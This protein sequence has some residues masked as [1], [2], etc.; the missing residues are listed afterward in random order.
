MPFR[1]VR[2]REGRNHRVYPR[3]AR[4]HRAGVAHCGPHSDAKSRH[5]R[6]RARD[7]RPVLEQPTDQLVARPQRH[8]STFSSGARANS[9]AT[10]GRCGSAPWRT[11]YRHCG[12]RRTMP[13][14]GYRRRFPRM[15]IS[16]LVRRRVRAL[17]ARR[18]A[19]C[20]RQRRGHPAPVLR[21]LLGRAGLIGRIRRIHGLQFQRFECVGPRHTRPGHR[22]PR[23]GLACTGRSGRL[24]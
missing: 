3:R 20:P 11:R 13:R 4:A 12:E 1:S 5:P 23:R 24:E 22:R 14:C 8:R 18:H 19:A 2:R 17:R 10:S 21:S 15:C 7:L 6:H 9:A 16:L